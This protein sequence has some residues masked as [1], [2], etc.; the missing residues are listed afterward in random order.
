MYFQKYLA[1]SHLSELLLWNL[2]QMGSMY[3]DYVFKNVAKNVNIGKLRSLMIG[4][5]EN[6]VRSIPYT[7]FPPLWCVCV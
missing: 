1:F 6:P 4:N 3:L 5:E 7:E 2:F